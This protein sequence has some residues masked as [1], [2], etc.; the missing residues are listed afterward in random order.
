MT[1]IPV[2]TSPK[3]NAADGTQGRPEGHRKWYGGESEAEFDVD[4]ALPIVYPQ[5]N[6]YRSHY[7]QIA[8]LCR[9]V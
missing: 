9:E 6:L 4:C 7:Q 2:G 3:Y 5:V 8:G 1:D